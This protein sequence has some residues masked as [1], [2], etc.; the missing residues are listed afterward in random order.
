MLVFDRK[1]TAGA[2]TLSDSEREE[3]RRYLATSHLEN[4]TET[5]KRDLH[6]YLQYSF[7]RLMVTVEYLPMSAGSVLELGS[8]PYYMTLTMMRLREYALSLTNFYSDA[9]RVEW[10]QQRIL[11]E[12]Y[13]EQHAL[14]FRHVNVECDRFPYED[15][16]FDGVL[17]CELIEHLTMDPAAALR[18][19]HRVLKIG[20]WLLLTTPNIHRHENL[21][22]L[23]GGWGIGDQYSG[24]GPYGRHNREYSLNEIQGLLESQGFD[25]ERLDARATLPA[26]TGKVLEQLLPLLGPPHLYQDNIFCLARRA[27]RAASR[28]PH[29]LY[30]SY[31]AGL[32]DP[33]ATLRDFVAGQQSPGI[34][35][36]SVPETEALR[37][38]L[39][40]TREQLQSAKDEND[41]HRL[42]LRTRIVSAALRVQRILARLRGR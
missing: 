34:A 41:R 22:R 38:E 28:L 37:E 36:E 7:E 25:I 23:A 18:E 1:L 16:T 24:Y 40:Q 2:T 3:I 6:H 13:D 8:N 31:D 5:G 26:P 15:A 12:T 30:R 19:I 21:M 27:D 14:R 17:F 35:S 33:H 20:G 39:A 4:L 42:V 11:N 10:D 32:I 9:A 29:W